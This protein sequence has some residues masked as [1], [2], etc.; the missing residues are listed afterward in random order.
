[1]DAEVHPRERDEDA[2]R[3]HDGAQDA[4]GV[5]AGDSTE[6]SDRRLRVTAGEGV[7]R[8]GFARGLHDWKAWVFDPR[9]RDAE[10]HFQKLVEYR[11]QKSDAEKIIALMLIKAP[12]DDQSDR[13]EYSLFT[14]KSDDRKQGVEKGIP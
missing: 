1:M 13:D 11:T 4:I 7:A 14:A 6:K 2:K 10:D 12:E 5:G 3:D 8:R 9:A